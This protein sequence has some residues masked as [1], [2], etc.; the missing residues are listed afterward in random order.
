MKKIFLNVFIIIYSLASFSQTL[1]VSPNGNDFSGE[2]TLLNPFLT[3]QKA[4]E[5]SASTV[6]LLEGI[7]TNFEEITAQDLN[8][9]ANPGDNVVFNGTI[10]INNPG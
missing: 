4:I 10:T 2:G 9:L 3:I 5:S 7:Y 8:I 6:Y 1:Y